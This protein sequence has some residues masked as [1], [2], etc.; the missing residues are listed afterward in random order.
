MKR[1]DLYYYLTDKE[2]TMKRKLLTIILILT[3]LTPLIP[4]ESHTA[5][6]TYPY[7]KYTDIGGHWAGEAIY[8][9][10]GLGYM[11]GIGNDKFN[12]NAQISYGEIFALLVKVRGLEAYAQTLEPDNWIQAAYQVGEEIGLIENNRPNPQALVT[13]EDAAYLLGKAIDKDPLL[14]DSIVMVKNFKDYS[15]ITPEKTPY[16]EIVIQEG[17]MKGDPKNNFKPKAYITRGEIAQIISNGKSK[18]ISLRNIQEKHGEIVGKELGDL[19]IYNVDTTSKKTKYLEEDSANFP[20]Y[21]NKELYSASVLREGNNLTYYIDGNGRV[22]Y[23]KILQETPKNLEGTIETIDLVN[24]QITLLD[25]SNKRHRLKVDQYHDMNQLYYGQ[26]LILGVQ[27]DRIS[28]LITVEEEDPE[29]DGYI[30]PGT[31]F[32]VGKVLFASSEEIEIQADRGREIFQIDSFYTKLYKKGQEVD[33]FQLKEGDRVLLNF[34]DIYS[35]TVSE[36]KIEDE[37]KHIEGIMR[38]TIE[39]VDE[40]NKEI[41]LKD[42]KEYILGSWQPMPPKTK[43]KV[44]T[45]EIYQG[46]K[47]ISLSNL[48]KLKGQEAYIAYENSFGAKAIGKMTIKSGPAMEY[49]DRLEDIDFGLERLTLNTNSF[50]FHGGTILVKDNRLVDIL[51]L[52]KDQSLFIA[53]DYKNGIRAASFIS[54][55]GTSPMDHRLDESRLLVFK[56]KIEDILDYKILVGDKNY[57]T[58]QELIFTEETLVY[59][60]SLEKAI[61]IKAFRDSRYIDLI[62]IQDSDLRERLESDF[63]KNKTAYIIGREISG[64]KE[65]LAINLIPD[66]EGVYSENVNLAYNSKGKIRNIDQATRTLQLSQVENYNNLRGAWERGMDETI[67]LNKSLVLLND[68]AIPLDQLYKIRKNTSAYLVREKKTAKASTYILVIED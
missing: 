68:K 58:S 20:V 27:G 34:D 41:L 45:G 63:Y 19:S 14:G 55:E 36:I 29:R 10:S 6:L 62:D 25:F 9:V 52:E 53:S 17:Y 33:L 3:I 54:I 7:I 5:S 8:D 2:L 26:E 51:N 24:R 50:N 65:A 4:G 39:I 59:D 30:I 15:N 40:R 37:E 18:L 28:Q 60:G 16:I 12:P 44:G 1:E 32:R 56:G 42:G 64:S 61:P 66:E 23:G 46:G 13:R 11:Q 22:I 31:R 57:G 35:S 43:I 49:K 38:A 21:M 67:D 48:N 47:K